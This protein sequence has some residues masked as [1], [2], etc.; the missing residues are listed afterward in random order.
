M[1]YREVCAYTCTY[2]HFFIYIYEGESQEVNEKI[3]YLVYIWVWQN[4]VAESISD[5][6]HL[7]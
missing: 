2:R 5:S 1:L 6:N 7:I 3:A 4:S